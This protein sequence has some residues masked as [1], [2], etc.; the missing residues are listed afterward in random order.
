LCTRERKFDQ[1]VDDEMGDD[2]DLRAKTTHVPIRANDN[3]ERVRG[4]LE[5][6]LTQH[7]A[8]RA[9]GRVTTMQRER[10]SRILVIGGDQVKLKCD[11]SDSFEVKYLALSHM[12]G[13]DPT[14]QLRLVKPR[15]DKFQQGIPWSE[16]PYIFKEAITMAWKIGYQYIWIHSY[17]G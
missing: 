11:W 15:L 14:Q 17:V 13:P 9:V 8:C 2:L 16:L 3:I 6:C 12:W 1:I 4:W 7:S 10:P 5:T